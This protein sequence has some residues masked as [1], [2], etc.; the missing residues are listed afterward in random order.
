MLR[1]QYI[2]LLIVVIAIGSCAQ[3]VTYSSKINQGSSLDRF[4]VNQ[5]TAGMTKSE[6]KRLLGSPIIVDIFHKNR[7]DYV[8]Y[9]TDTKYRL[10]ILFEDDK[11]VDIES[12]NLNE[13]SEL[14]EQQQKAEDASRYKY[15]KKLALE[16]AK[17]DKIIADKKQ[18]EAELQAKI[19]VNKRINAIKENSASKFTNIVNSNN[20]IEK[21]RIAI[22]ASNVIVDATPSIESTVDIKK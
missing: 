16:Q 13:L 19:A 21:V 14:S 17:K 5:L 20:K 4:T 22:N 15:N 11:I 2:L 10:R 18:L 6:V 12:I 3:K 7:W 9:S 1:L 8:N